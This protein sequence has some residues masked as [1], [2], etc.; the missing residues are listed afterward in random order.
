MFAAN[1]PSRD[2][3]ARVRDCARKSRGRDRRVRRLTDCGPDTARSSAV[4]EPR[5]VLELARLLDADGDR[6]GARVEYERFVRLWTGAD[7]SLPEL[8][9]AKRA[10][11]GR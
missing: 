10:L 7:A 5:Y 2:G 9:E 4:L 1:P 11:G 6:A 3:L 8:I